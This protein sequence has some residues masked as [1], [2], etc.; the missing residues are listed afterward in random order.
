MTQEEIQ[1]QVDQARQD[2]ITLDFSKWSFEQRQA[3]KSFDH[4]SWQ[5]ARE[6]VLSRQRTE[7]GIARLSTPF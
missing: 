4:Q 7:N 5:T 6:F 2:A 1:K 3:G